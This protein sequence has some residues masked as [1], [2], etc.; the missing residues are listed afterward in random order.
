M[1]LWSRWIGTSD[2]ASRVRLIPCLQEQNV[3]K[4]VQLG[5]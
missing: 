2:E 4:Q 5:T 3:N 1:I